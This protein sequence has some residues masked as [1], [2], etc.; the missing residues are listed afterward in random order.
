[1]HLD[2]VFSVVKNN[3]IMYSESRVLDTIE[4]SLKIY[5]YNCINID[6]DYDGI[7]STNF[8]IIREHVI[9]NQRVKEN[10]T[11]IQQLIKLGYVIHYVDI[12]DLWRE[13][14]GIRCLT[15]WFTKLEHQLIY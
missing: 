11:V 9:H 10:A 15:Q 1:M 13:G 8:L 7:L 14:G 2:C 6:D 5:G 12:G 4:S 3:T